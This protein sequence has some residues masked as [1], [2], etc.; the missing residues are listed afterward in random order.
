MSM[1]TLVIYCLTTPDSSWFMDLIFQFPMQYCSYS[2]RLYFH[3]QTHPQ[4]NVSTLA[5]LILPGTII[6]YC[7]LFPR[8]ILETFWPRGS[9]SGIISFCLIILSMEFS[10]EWVAFPPPVNYVCQNSSLWSIY[11][12]SMD[13]SFIELCK[14]FHHDKAVFHKGEL[15]FNKI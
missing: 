10:R 14:L 15:L 11:L 8:S 9:Y 7:L 13:H 5:Q 4:V 2:F 12:H 6:N 3:Y 1:F